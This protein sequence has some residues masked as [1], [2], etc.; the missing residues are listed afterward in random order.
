MES[1][2]VYISSKTIEGK[3]VRALVDIKKGGIVL[4]IDDSRVVDEEH[5]LD[6]SK[7]ETDTH[8]DWLI[9]KV[10]LMQEPERYINHSCDPNTFVKTMLG[11]RYV[12]ALRDIAKDEEITY[13]YCINGFGD[14][15]W[16]CACGSQRCRKT[17][18]AD[19]FQ[20]P[21]ELQIEYLPL[22]DAWFL[23]QRKHEVEGLI[24]KQ[25]N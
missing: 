16:T 22:L 23:E 6:A 8:C 11:A 24:A 3:G 19:F 7:G 14:V 4:R 21:M 10:V 5:P 12:I 20:L 1:K 13:D 18:H 2:K 25:L 15:T 17:I 9:T